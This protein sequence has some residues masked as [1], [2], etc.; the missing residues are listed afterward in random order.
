MDDHDIKK[1]KPGDTIITQAGVW[2]VLTNKPDEK[3]VDYAIVYKKAGII[4]YDQLA[5]VE[6]QG[7][8]V[9]EPAQPI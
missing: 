9:E 2:I 8:V 3:I 7:S 6:K 1:L 4:T 5:I